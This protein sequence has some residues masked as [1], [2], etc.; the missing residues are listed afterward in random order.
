MTNTAHTRFPRQKYVRQLRRLRA[1]LVAWREL[2][3][4]AATS[5]PIPYLAGG[6]SA[7]HTVLVDL[8]DLVAVAI[9][10]L[11]QLPRLTA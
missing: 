7:R 1:D 4:E 6:F 2:Y 5:S 3:A 9:A 8:V 10:E 11:E